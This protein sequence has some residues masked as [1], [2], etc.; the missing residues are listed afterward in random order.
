MAVLY[1]EKYI[2]GAHR[3]YNLLAKEVRSAVNDG[4]RFKGTFYL[5]GRGHWVI[6]KMLC[7]QWK[8]G[9]CLPRG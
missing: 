6:S 7:S 5:E 2:I 3:F 8:G 1:R 9:W 4:G